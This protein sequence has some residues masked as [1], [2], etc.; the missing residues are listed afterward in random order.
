MKR[1][2]NVISMILGILFV[3]GV[4]FF[5]TVHY[6]VKNNEKPI[7]RIDYPAGEILNVVTEQEINIYNKVTTIDIESAFENDESIKKEYT[8]NQEEIYQI[9]DII[10]NANFTKETCDGLP[11]YYIKFNSEN[12][13]GFVNYGVEIYENEYHISSADKGEAILSN[14]QKEQLDQIINKYFDEK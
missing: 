8:L 1:K 9:F 3:L 13:R 12:K 11:N 14:N 4:I 2:L 6:R 7:S 5:V 10:D